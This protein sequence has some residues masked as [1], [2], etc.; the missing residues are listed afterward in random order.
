MVVGASS[1]L[2]RCI[3]VGLAQRGDQVA[4]L[5]RR[6][7]R[8]EAAAKEAGPNAT[9]IECDVTD[10]ESC[11]AAIGRAADALGGIDNLVYT[12]AV[13]PLVRMVDTDADTWRRIFDTNVIGASLVTAAAMPHLTASAGK[14][15][16]LSSDAGTFGPPWPGLG[17]Y[18]VSKA[19]LE[20]LVEAWRAE[21]S[22]VGFTNLIVGECAGGEG[23]AATGMNADWDMDLA[24]KAV[25]LWSS[26]GCMPG[27]L[28][29]VDDLIDVVH[30]ILRTNASTSMP[31]VVARGAPASPAAFA[32]ANQS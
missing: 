25:P 20:R 7:Q 31:L 27:K 4:L 11:R 2:G 24:M 26:R 13:G 17:A 18:G 28:M 6:L 1:G 14:A 32:E 15:V 5:A 22:D 16:Y 30:T 23:D 12:P 19:A 21:H 29:P 10:E 8:I 9:A 3:G